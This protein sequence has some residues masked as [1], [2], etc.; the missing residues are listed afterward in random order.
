MKTMALLLMPI[1]ALPWICVFGGSTPLASRVMID[2]GMFRSCCLRQLRPSIRTMSCLIRVNTYFD[3]QRVT[4]PRI[5]PL[6][7]LFLP[8]LFLVLVLVLVAWCV[9]GAWRRCLLRVGRVVDRS[10]RLSQT[11][12]LWFLCGWPGL[13]NMRRFRCC[14]CPGIALTRGRGV[15]LPRWHVWRLEALLVLFGSGCFACASFEDGRSCVRSEGAL[16]SHVAV[17]N[18]RGTGGRWRL[19]VYPLPRRNGTSSVWC[20]AMLEGASPNFRLR[21]GK[22]GRWSRRRRRVKWSAGVG[23]E[24]PASLGRLSQCV[25]QP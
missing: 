22:V 11:R 8:V 14:R 21:S 24:R 13:V 16:A 1:M 20:L 17:V 23:S 4:T 3:C 19:R 9:S 2:R 18:S 15:R 7:L 12:W 6:L 10:R 25:C 5:P